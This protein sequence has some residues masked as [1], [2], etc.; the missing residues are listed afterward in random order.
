MP[1]KTEQV[2][3]AEAYQVVLDTVLIRLQEIVQGLKQSQGKTENLAKVIQALHSLML[4]AKIQDFAACV[5]FAAMKG[6]LEAVQSIMRDPLLSAFYTFLSMPQANHTLFM[7]WKI[8]AVE[9]KKKLF[10]K[11]DFDYQISYVL[12]KQSPYVEGWNDIAFERQ[13]I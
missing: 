13:N 7:D 8:R 1:E 6:N 12:T 10:G 5:Q 2:A 9:Y 11:S 4:W 3:S